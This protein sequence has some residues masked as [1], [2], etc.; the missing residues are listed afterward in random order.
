MPT[1]Y[2]SGQGEIG[3]LIQSCV[4]HPNLKVLTS[5]PPPA[6]PGDLFESDQMRDL[7]STMEQ[8][9]YIILDSPPAMGFADV[10]ILATLVDGVMIVVHGQNTS[11]ATLLRVK[12]RL[13][14]LGANIYGVVLNHADPASHET[15]YGDYYGYY[16]SGEEQEAI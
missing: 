3:S 10:G 1:T 7:L 5:G 15:F 9:A 13:L 6:N 4:G 11:R 12:Q 14:E 2:L 8:F 16:Q